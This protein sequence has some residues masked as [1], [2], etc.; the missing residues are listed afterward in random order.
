[1][2]SSLFLYYSLLMFSY[3]LIFITSVHCRMFCT[4][5]WYRC[6]LANTNLVFLS[7]RLTKCVRLVVKPLYVLWQRLFFIVDFDTDLTNLLEGVLYLDYCCEGSILYQ[8]NNCCLV[9]HSLLFF[10]A[11]W[12]SWSHQCILDVYELNSWLVHLLVLSEIMKG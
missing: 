12:C 5:L 9:Y 11:F 7:L 2:S 4:G 6:I 3:K 8:R 1:M 10:W